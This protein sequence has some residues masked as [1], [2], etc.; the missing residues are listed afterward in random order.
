M[1]TPKTIKLSCAMFYPKKN[2]QLFAEM[3]AQKAKWYHRKTQKM[4]KLM[5]ADVE[6][7]DEK[8]RSTGNNNNNMLQ[9]QN[10]W[11]G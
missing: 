1:T 8:E 4:P 2:A 10:G 11:L 7:V 5:L 6:K 3:D 9:P